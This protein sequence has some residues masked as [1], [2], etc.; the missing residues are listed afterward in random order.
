MAK[1]RRKP[2]TPLGK[3]WYFIWYEDSLAS[4]AV[5]I[6]LAFILIKFVVYPLLGLVMGTS[7]PVVAVV[8]ESMDHGYTRNA[9]EK[10]YALCDDIERQRPADHDFWEVCGDWYEDYGI[11]EEEFSTFPFSEGFSKGD[12]IVL[13]GKDPEAIEV[14][15]IIVFQAVPTNKDANPPYPI[16]HRVIGA[17]MTATGHVFQTKGDHNPDMIDDPARGIVEESVYEQQ[18]I[19]VG[20]TRIPLLGWVKIAFVELFQGKSC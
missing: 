20:V 19:G 1:Q 2:V 18:I 5:N 12:I 7:L 9:C 11:L 8:S 14:G 15:D 10:T 17:E 13:R 4:W 6:V 16:I 3:A